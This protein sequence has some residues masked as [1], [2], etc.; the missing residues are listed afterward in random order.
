MA[1]HA[2][3][4]LAVLEGKAL[5]GV[6]TE[7][8]LFSLQRQS[9]GLLSSE[10]R[11]AQTVPELARSAHGIREWTALLVAQGATPA[12]LTRLI[13]RLNDQLTRRILELRAEDHAMALSSACWMALGSEGREEQT[14]A[15]DQDNA[16]I[17][18]AGAG[19]GLRSRWL[20]FARSVNEDLAACGF[21]LCKGGIMASNPAWCLEWPEWHER[22]ALW[23]EQGA[24]SALLNASIF[25]DLR[26]L[27]GDLNLAQ[28]LRAQVALLACRTPRFLKQMSDNALRNGPPAGLAA[29]PWA[30]WLP[31]SLD[32][33]LDLKLHGT[34]PLVDAARLLALAEG[35]TA[36]GTA[37][38]LQALADAGRIQPAEKTDWIDA[39]EFFQTLRL[40]AQHRDVQEGSGLPPNSL[41]MHDLSQVDQRA[42]RE[43]WRQMRRLQQRLALDFPG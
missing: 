15:T 43:S 36:T 13:S 19:Q 16:L 27:A 21:P 20:D 40:R 9:I 10:I 11:R 33:T 12:F 1:A 14:I 24:P 22:F 38:R 18:P 28:S 26:G 34:M 7:R 23:I 2:V 35:I 25:F 4:H 30:A 17:L 39:F 37:A 6:V 42:L 31:G 29:S 5:L 41:R 3:R 32:Q 8:D